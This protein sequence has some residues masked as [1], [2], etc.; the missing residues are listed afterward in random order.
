MRGVLR[1]R[2]P[3]QSA[4]LIALVIVALV[5]IV[6]LA[7]DGSNAY[8]T[9]RK[10]QST[11]NAAAI[12]GTKRL[13]MARDNPGSYTDTD[14]RAEID[15]I[16]IENQFSTT[17]ITAYYLDYYGNVIGEVGTIGGTDTP[18]PQN[19]AY[20]EVRV[21]RGMETYFIRL[22]GFP[23]VDVVASTRAHNIGT[24]Q[25]GCT[26]GIYPIGVRDQ[27][28]ELG[29]T[30]WI[31]DGDPLDPQLPGNF[32]WLR[33]REDSKFGNTTYLEEALTPP[34]TLGDP[35]KGYFDGTTHVLGPG[36]PMWGNTGLSSSGDIEA[37]LEYFISSQE[38]LI[39]PLWVSAGG[40]G[41]NTIYVNSGF[42][43]F[44]LQQVCFNTNP[45]QCPG[46]PDDIPNGSKALRVTFLGYSFSGCSVANPVNPGMGGG[47]Q[48]YATFQGLTYVCN[49]EAVILPPSQGSHLPVDIVHLID[50]SGSMSNPLVGGGRSKI[51]IEKE[52]VIYFN[53]L[54]NPEIGDR[55]GAVKF[56]KYNPDVTVLSPLTWDIAYL[57]S[58]IQTLSAT[59]WTPWAKAVLV[60]NA[61]L[62]GAGRNPDS[63]PV[64]I[65]ASDGAP[66]VDLDNET[67]GD[68][69]LF[70]W[71]AMTPGTLRYCF[72]KDT[73]SQYPGCVA[74]AGGCPLPRTNDYGV[75]VLIDALDA[76]DVV[77][78]R[79]SVADTWWVL[80]HGGSCTQGN[81]C[82]FYGVVA[83]PETE[84]FVIA[85]KGQE[86]F[87]ASVLRYAATDPDSEHYFEVYQ[88]SDV[89]D[90]YTY[91]ANAI[92]GQFPACYIDS[93]PA[94][95]GGGVPLQVIAGG[96]V[97]ASGTSNPDGSYSIPA[98][99]ADP[100]TIYSIT[101]TVTI[102]GV[103]YGVAASCGDGGQVGVQAPLPVVYDVPLYLVPSEEAQCPEGTIIIPHP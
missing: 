36:R 84:I 67:E 56:N 1:F 28:F 60:G 14:I 59:G 10:A 83:H 6:G 33:W 68:Y 34:G 43:V 38:P 90:I 49:S 25:P 102:G 13:A 72:L 15:R 54:M 89:T 41:A 70:E 18:P 85:I 12:A 79:G 86:Q 45:H 94:V 99:P 103:P 42:G 44:T 52:A 91:I 11:A 51:S 9:Q 75:E 80:R 100:Y 5:L 64:M 93:Q 24:G 4:V 92:T 77:T 26:D 22:G 2:S 73:C 62:Y 39:L 19:A 31:W 97:V 55:L 7:V 23:T 65:I 48:D 53:S 20:I 17:E 87:S 30:Y 21:R 71:D 78:G 88:E 58:K 46:V 37:L 57:N 35:E 63:K 16:I 29:Q 76:I 50:S 98:I 74:P 95:Y 96:T 66:T 3:G 47:S 8:A 82:P 81:D 32:G 61:T 69:Q 40:Q 27:G 101:G